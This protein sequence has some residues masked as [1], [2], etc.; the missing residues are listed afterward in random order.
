MAV[1]P[2]SMAAPVEAVPYMKAAL[3]DSHR[4]RLRRIRLATRWSWASTSTP[5]LSR[6][7]S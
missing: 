5:S 3:V 7:R 4:E 6:A 1:V 2:L